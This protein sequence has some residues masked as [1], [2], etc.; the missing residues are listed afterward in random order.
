[1]LNSR[2]IA[3]GGVGYSS[4]VLALRGLYPVDTPVID[5]PVGAGVAVVV[6]VAPAAPSAPSAPKMTTTGNEKESS[7]KTRWSLT[8]L[9]QS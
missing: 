2:A 1:M 3:L 6:V 4:R 5:P 8:L 9:W 7:P